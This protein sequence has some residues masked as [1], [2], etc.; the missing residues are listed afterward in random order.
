MEYKDY[1][2]I[3]G[4]N[5]KATQDEI[6]KAYHKLAIKY[7]PDKNKGNK[8]AEEKFKEIA[9]ANDVLSDPEKRRKY[10]ELGSNWSQYQ[11]YYPGNSQGYSRNYYR[12][13]KHGF[14]DNFSDIFGR[15]GG[16]SDFFRIFFGGDNDSFKTPPQKGTNLQARLYLTLEEANKG[17]RKI[18]DLGNEKI[19]LTIKPGIHDE[20]KLKISGKGKGEK[21][22]AVPGDLYII[23]NLKPHPVFTRKGNDLYCKQPIEITTAVLGG[24]IQVPSLSGHINITIPPETD[25][26]KT[27]RL[28]GAG[29]PDYEKPSVK[30][31]LFVSVFISVPKNISHEERGLYEKLSQIKKAIR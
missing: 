5:K 10:D 14:P 11:N 6:K 26:G 13:S 18:I 21:G 20:Q 19:R 28:K 4:V 30:G 17:C 22:N 9:E 31:D 23:I 25:N 3:L 12:N 24:K 1:Y 8:Q 2:K 27:F 29:M 7:H 16:F 15:H